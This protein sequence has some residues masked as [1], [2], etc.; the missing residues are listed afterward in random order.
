LIAAQ[1]IEIA[2][3]HRR[4][5][6]ERGAAIARVLADHPGELEPVELGHLHVHEHH[7][8][9]VLQQLLERGARGA[10]LDEVL[11]ELAEDRFV[12]QQ[13]RRL[14]VDQEDIDGVGAELGHGCL[15]F[16][17]AQER[18]LGAG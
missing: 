18:L 17:L 2:H 11:A 4:H 5:E 14:I 8:D 9:L 10:R 3:V 13:L 15:R 1:P 7:R 6:D 16:L 12:G